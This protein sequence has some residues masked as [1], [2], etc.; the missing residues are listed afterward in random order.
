[1]NPALNLEDLKIFIKWNAQSGCQQWNP[2]QSVN[3]N[4]YSIK[5][6]YNLQVL[7][8]VLA[9]GRVWLGWRRLMMAAGART[10][11]WLRIGN[12]V[13]WGVWNGGY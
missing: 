12:V 8:L 9:E 11:V 5:P 3:Q 4:R 1:M 10:W 2:Q 7:V 6:V 13:T